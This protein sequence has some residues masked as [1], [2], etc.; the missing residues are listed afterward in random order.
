MKIIVDPAGGGARD[1]RNLLEIIERGI[2]H[3]PGRPEMHQQRLLPA[4]P[5]SGHFIE[6][7]RRKI[8]RSLLAMSADRE[9]MS[10]VAEPLEVKERRRIGRQCDLSSAGKVEYLATGIAVGA[11]GDADHRNIVDSSVFKGLTNRRKL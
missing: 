10:L 8:L 9:S 4:G 5:D 7:A 1:S 6:R 11:L 3:C 2:A